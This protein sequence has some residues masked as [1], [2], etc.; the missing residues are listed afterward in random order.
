MR[1]QTRAC[2]T[3]TATRASTLEERDAAE[4]WLLQAERDR[5]SRAGI[6]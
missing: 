4:A 1:A 6:S 2:L 3:A 5:R